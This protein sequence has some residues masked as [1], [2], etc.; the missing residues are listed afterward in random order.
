MRISRIISSLSVL[1]FRKCALKLI[2][3]LLENNFKKRDH[4][5]DNEFYNQYSKTENLVNLVFGGYQ[6]DYTKEE[7]IFFKNR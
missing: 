6:K 7:S 2:E 5:L 1:G 4:D 3:F